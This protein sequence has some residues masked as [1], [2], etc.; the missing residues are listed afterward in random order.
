[1]YTCLASEEVS[2][3]S[4]NREVV[5]AD[6]DN[7]KDVPSLAALNQTPVPLGLSESNHLSLHVTLRHAFQ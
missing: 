7:P 4:F 3:G 6:P 1:M 2:G 5:S